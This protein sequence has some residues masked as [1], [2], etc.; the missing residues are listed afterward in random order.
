MRLAGGGVDG[1]A[2]DEIEAGWWVTEDR[3][4][5]GIATEAMRAAIDDLWDRTDADHIAAYLDDGQ[6]EPS[7]RLAAKLG[8]TVRGEGRGRSGAPMTVFELRRDV[9]HRRR[10]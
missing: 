3:R 9:W 2:P 10:T 1:I 8:F 7:H 4:N 6:N 5:D